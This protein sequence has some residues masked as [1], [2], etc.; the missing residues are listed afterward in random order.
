M[1]IWFV[2]FVLVVAISFVLAVSSMGD[3]QE[4]PLKSGQ[5][6]SLFLIQKPQAFRVDQLIK[7]HEL[8]VGGGLLFSLE[9]LFKGSKKALIIFGPT[10]VL[11]SFAQ[12][13]SLLELEDFSQKLSEEEGFSK[14]QIASW[15]MGLK[16]TLATSPQFGKFWSET[17]PLLE[18]EQFWWQIVLSPLPSK[19]FWK[20]I[21]KKEKDKDTPKFQAAVRVVLQTGD[22]IR[23]TQLQEEFLKIGSQ[24]GLVML[25]QAYSIP[26][27]IK[28][29]QDRTLP[30]GSS[31]L[32]LDPEEILSLID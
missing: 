20:K 23:A 11:R 12:I 4:H 9:K 28:F 14:R 27:M 3:Y 24:A 26:Q 18:D 15:E 2:F 19:S 1:L 22:K 17:P 29:Y 25:P 7:L 21:R 6:Y 8:T 5:P 30:Q 31:F 10:T 13:L 16:K 32:A